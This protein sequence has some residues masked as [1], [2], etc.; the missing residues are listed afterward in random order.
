MRSSTLK[1]GCIRSVAKIIFCSQT[2]SYIKNTLLTAALP[3][4]K[5]FLSF[6]CREKTYTVWN[7]KTGA[8]TS[9][10][11][12][13]VDFILAAGP[14]KAD[15]HSPA[16]GHGANQNSPVAVAVAAADSPAAGDKP[17][18]SSPAASAGNNADTQQGHQV[19]FDNVMFL[20]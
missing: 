12:S 17:A 20:V 2:K 8:R 5:A 15:P 19:C 10:Y 9:N 1:G 7:Q 3:K 13:R 4:S 11:G 6:P 14:H 18:T 16:A